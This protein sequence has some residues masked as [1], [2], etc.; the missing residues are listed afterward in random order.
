MIMGMYHSTSGKARFD[1]HAVATPYFFPR[2][3]L[4]RILAREDELRAS[5][6]IQAQYT[7]AL[8]EHDEEDSESM[9]RVLR[10]LAAI[11]NELQLKVLSGERI[12]RLLLCSTRAFA[13][14]WRGNIV[15]LV[16]TAGH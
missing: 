11:T 13:Q 9:Q 3:I 8:L 1:A 7:A 6:S 5:T 14:E 16:S 15:G 12:C 10:K 2:E 4:R